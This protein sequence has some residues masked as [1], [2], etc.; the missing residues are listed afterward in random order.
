[1]S[2]VCADDGE[3]G[4]PL[5]IGVEYGGQSSGVC[6]VLETL[7]KKNCCKQTIALTLKTCE[8]ESAR[9]DGGALNGKPGRTLFPSKL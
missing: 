6:N 4:E 8:R 9:R 2:V 1:M 5:W 7:Q 3:E